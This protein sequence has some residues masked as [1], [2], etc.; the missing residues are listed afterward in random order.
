M[1]SVFLKV[2]N[3][4][5]AATFLV[6][7]VLIVRALFKKA[8]KSIRCALWG[9]VGL[10]LCLPVSIPSPFSLIPSSQTVNPSIVYAQ[11]PAID[12]GIEVVNRAINPLL[13]QAFAPVP[14]ASANPLQVWLF[15]A[16]WVW[17]V[18]VGLMLLYGAVSY[19][20]LMLR[21]APSVPLRDNIRLSDRIATP[22]MMGIVRP[23][24]YLPMGLEEGVMELAIA[25]EWAH[26]ERLDHVTRPLGFLLLAVYWFNPLLW[27]S[28]VLF[29]RD[30][31]L[32]CDEKVL[33][34]LGPEKKKA[35]SRALLAC[36][37][38]RRSLAACPLAF[39]ETQVKGRIENILSY[40]A[41]PRWALIAAA[42]LCA[43]L[44][45]GFLT[46]PTVRDVQSAYAPV[47]DLYYTAAQEQWSAEKLAAAGIKLLPEGSAFAGYEKQMMDPEKLGYL[48]QDLDG[49]GKQELLIGRLDSDW[50][51]L[52]GL[53]T[54]KN[55]QAVQVELNGGMV[56]LSPDGQ[57]LEYCAELEDG[58]HVFYGKLTLKRG[59]LVVTEGVIAHKTDKETRNRTFVLLDRFYLAS[60]S[61]L[62]PDEARRISDEE[63]WELIGTYDCPPVLKDFIPLTEYK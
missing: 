45:L 1:E 23:R 48:F 55:G 33:Q 9:L 54:V 49:D 53:Y 51:T 63:G 41:P 6:L 29:C 17:V 59:V 35:Y 10:R 50:G 16:A 32:A 15:I 11:R 57:I 46:D 5:M 52:L 7:A 38:P 20:L 58:Y 31:E 25:H 34:S 3:N 4:S 43:V 40:K 44:A 39:G 12:S 37:A 27:L 21:M 61:D 14:H 56:D 36:S 60:G 18:G 26:V 28:F 42:G 19:L 30:M 2:L 22:F 62:T 13:T 47:L 8:P 24:L